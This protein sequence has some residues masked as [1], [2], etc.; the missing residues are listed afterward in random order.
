[1]TGPRSPTSP[2]PQE[3]QA[4]AI[5]GP[6]SPTT[7]FPLSDSRPSSFNK[8]SLRGEAPELPDSNYFSFSLGSPGNYLKKRNQLSHIHSTDSPEEQLTSGRDVAGEQLVPL[9]VRPGSECSSAVCRLSLNRSR[10]REDPDSSA[11]RCVITQAAETNGRPVSIEHCAELLVSFANDVMLLDV[12]PYA[13]FSKGNIKGSLNLCIPTTLLRRPSFDTKKLANTFTDEADRKNFARWKQYR[14]IIVYDASTVSMKDATPLANLLKKFSVEGWKGDGLILMG[15]YRAFSIKFPELTQQQQQALSSQTKESS[16][17]QIELPQSAP[18]AGGCNIPESSNIAIPFFGNIRQHM[19]LLDGS[20]SESKRR[21]LPP[22]LRQ[23]SDPTDQGRIAALRFLDIEKAELERMKQALS[24]PSTKTFRVAGIEK[25]TKNRYNDIYPYDHTRVRLHDI[26]HGGCD[27]VNASYMKAEYSDRYY[28]ATQAPVPDTFDDFWRV[29]W[30]QDVRLVVSLTAEVERGQVKCHPYWKSGTYG[31]LHVNNFSKKYIPMESAALQQVGS[32]APVEPAGNSSIVVRHFGLSHSDTS[33][34]F[35]LLKRRAVRQLCDSQFNTSCQTF[36]FGDKSPNIKASSLAL[37]GNETLA[38][39][40]YRNQKV[41][42]ILRARQGQIAL[43]AEIRLP[44]NQSGSAEILKTAFDGRDRVY[45]L[46]RFTP[47][48][49]EPD[50]DAEHP[51]VKRARESGDYET[52]VYLSCHS[53]EF[54]DGQVNVTAFRERAG[55]EPSAL[56][57]ASDGSFA[58]SWYHRTFPI[59][60]V[61]FYT[62][63]NGSEYE[64]G[65]NLVGFLHTT[66]QLH[67]WYDNMRGPLVTGIAFNDRS[68]QLLYY[69]QAKSLYASFQKIDRVGPPTLY[70]NS[71][72]VHFTTNLS[73]LFSIGIPFFGTHETL[74]RNGLEVCQWKYLSIGIATHREEN[75]TVACL[76]RSEATCRASNCGHHLNLERGRRLMDWVVVARLW[77]FRDSTNSLGCK[78]AT[79]KRGTRIAVANWGVIYVWALEPEAL[80]DKDSQEYYHPSW[81]SSRTGL[82]ELHPIVLNLDAVCFQLQFTDQENELIA[83]TDRGIMLW[84]L[85][86]FRRGCRSCQQLT[87]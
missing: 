20:L 45:I 44:W 78:V 68:T 22:W 67:K 83:I 29:V 5:T 57:V 8:S 17:M 53:L 63:E 75:W 41:V 21:S 28:I 84:D 37:R 51:F 12:R 71:N 4:L 82:I 76:L 31:P 87:V 61:I 3:P 81:R 33:D 59:H 73:L 55:F 16:H 47:D 54:P 27:Y 24:R 19:D 64:I 52:A 2:W 11:S 43:L 23:V 30:E 70:E 77:G 86:P 42:Q 1:M 66:R 14:Y 32:R 80:I 79:S 65:H 34:L 74:N 38:F 18:V 48:I 56:A 7:F 50:P 10:V 15:G 85:T 60:T 9:E 46:H 35:L 69:Y 26:P 6:S 13:H 49:E 36:T 25:G 62:V 39:T 58:I 40:T 72:P